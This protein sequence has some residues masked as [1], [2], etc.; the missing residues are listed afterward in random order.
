MDQGFVFNPQVYRSTC[1]AQ[2]HKT[3][4]RWTG[5]NIMLHLKQGNRSEGFTLIELMIVIAIIAVLVALAVPAYN[6]YT[7]RAKVGECV[8]DVAV[9][10]VQISEYVQTLGDWPPS[11]EEA[12]ISGTGESKF[13]NAV[14]NYDGTT[15]AF[16][17]DV[18]EGSVDM[19]LGQVEPKMTPTVHPLSG[20][21]NWNCTVGVTAPGNVKYLP[22]T[23]RDT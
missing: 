13:C 14:A 21:I 12:G 1:E 15:G 19:L 6:D 16:F 22:A 5:I 7:I 4:E 17:I 18:D 20:N 23:C 8:N 11:V 9:A 3:G 2:A 10:K